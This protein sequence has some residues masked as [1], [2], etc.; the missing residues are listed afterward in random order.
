MRHQFC[1]EQWISAPVDLVFAFF[2]DPENLPRLMPRWQH[3]TIQQARLVTPHSGDRAE[4]DT[5]AENMAGAGSEMT[6]RFRPV[7]FCPI[8][9]SW[10]ARI[11]EFAWNNHF[12][13]EQL[14]GPFAYW[15]HCHYVKG[16]IQEDRNGTLVQDQ[17]EYE[18]PFSLVG[19]AAHSLFARRQ[20]VTIFRYR[21]KM[22]AK[23]FQAPDIRRIGS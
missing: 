1:T 15:H 23:I 9:A 17:L 22:L 3:A 21:Q 18:L 2:A 8:H 7:P 20:I 13:D 4:E 12:C 14:R 5:P 16:Q 11:T 19:E 10:Q 6:I